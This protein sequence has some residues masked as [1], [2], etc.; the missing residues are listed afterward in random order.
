MQDNGHNIGF[1][2]NFHFSRRIL[3][4][5]ELITSAP[6]GTAV[7]Y[8]QMWSPLAGTISFRPQRSALKTELHF[9]LEPPKNLKE[10][11]LVGRKIVNFSSAPSFD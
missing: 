5:M 8:R 7:S 4:K 6:G 9:S 1:Q 2:E 11:N 3:V 10:K